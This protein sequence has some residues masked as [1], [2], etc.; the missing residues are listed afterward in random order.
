MIEQGAGIRAIS[1]EKTGFAY[2]DEL[3]I[4]RKSVV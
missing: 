4:D 3:V 2:S 1:G